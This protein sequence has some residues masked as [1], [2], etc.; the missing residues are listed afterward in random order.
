MQNKQSKNSKDVYYSFTPEQYQSFEL[1]NGISLNDLDPSLFTHVGLQEKTSESIATKPYSYW[2]AVAKILF[3]SKTFI[4]CTSILLLIIL[5]SI[6]VPWG[7]EAVP[8]IRPG[9]SAQAPSAQHLFGL[10]KQGE[11][12]WI[13]IWLGLR[14]TL[15]FSFVV[16]ILQLSIGILIGLVW[17]YF[18]KL[19]ILFYQITAIILIAPQLVMIILIISIFGTGF[20]PMI[21]G[22]IVQAWIGP[23][24]NVRTTVLAVRDSDYN[25]ASLTLG[26]KSSKIIRKNILPKILPI[27][28]QVAVFSIPTAIS[29]ES[30]LSYLGQGF[31]DGIKTTSLGKILELAIG[32]TEWQVFPHLIIIPVIFIS[33][34]SLL[35]FLVLKVFADSLDPKNHR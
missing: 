17:G 27:L 26:S 7:K 6:I 33:S 31:V 15:A 28:I 10:G 19:D 20:W 11:D 35:F 2:K 21:L 22:V 4:I 13:E 16:T 23:A 3:T 34:I 25:V 32:G 9:S 24:L 14:T 8:L 5:M 12:Y 1:A 30:T 18:R 29:I